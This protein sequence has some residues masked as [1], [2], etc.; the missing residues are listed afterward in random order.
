MESPSYHHDEM[1]DLLGVSGRTLSRWNREGKGPPF[2][3]VSDR[4]KVYPADAYREWLA[5]RQQSVA[6]PGRPGGF[7]KRKLLKLKQRPGAR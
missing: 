2:V 3:F 5:A 7:G 4:I 6:E 1:A